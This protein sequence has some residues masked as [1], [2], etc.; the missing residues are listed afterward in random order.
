MKVQNIV[1]S[2][3]GAASV[4]SA[5]YSLTFLVID[6]VETK[7]WEYVRLN[8][9]KETYMPTKFKDS[10]GITPLDNDFRC[11]EGTFGN[12]AKTKVAEVAPGTKL[13]IKLGAKATM[14]HPG[15]AQVYMSKAP[16][17]VVEYDGSGD[18]F[19]I[20][21]ET[22]C[23]STA[24]KLQDTDWCTWD[25][26]RISFTIPP[27]TPPG[28]YLVRAE[29]IGLH[30]AHSGDA[31]FYYSCAQVKVTGNGTGTPGPLVKF[32]G[33]YV[34]D[35]PAIHI[36]IWGAK[37]YPYHVGP[38]VWQGQVDSGSPPAASSAPASSL[39]SATVSLVVPSAT[40]TLNTVIKVVT[41]SSTIPTTTSSTVPPE[42]IPTTTTTS[43]LLATVPSD[44]A[45]TATSSTYSDAASSTVA[46][47]PAT[48]TSAE[49]TPEELLFQ[50][51]KYSCY[52]S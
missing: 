38:I 6:G 30:G 32:P 25:K 11:N 26:D 45:V 51:K 8:T 49:L 33:A 34:A 27:G 41:T 2:L 29:H 22:V 40:T 52:L 19:K 1:A 10:P 14:R 31:E 36:N 50:G 4:V 48:S 39:P 3:L 17:K 15:P 24:D 23:G 28:E 12:A 21:D 7:A 42:V 5:H 13:A 20:H 9:R 44:S 16:G 37:D 46:A 18:W 47:L 35:D 43:T